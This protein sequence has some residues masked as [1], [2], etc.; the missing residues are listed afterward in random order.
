MGED[1]GVAPHI[2]E[3]ILGHKSGYRGGV[4]GVYNRSV[5]ATEVRNALLMWADHVRTI[6]DGS[7]RKVIPMRPKEVPA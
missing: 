7:D 5:Y 2:I 1:L 3:S 6:T 4:S